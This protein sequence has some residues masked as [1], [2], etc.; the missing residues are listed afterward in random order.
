MRERVDYQYVVPLKCEVSDLC[1]LAVLVSK[2]G[3]CPGSVIFF[4]C[5]HI[6]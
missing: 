2:N 4:F 5:I 1:C 3:C 6:C